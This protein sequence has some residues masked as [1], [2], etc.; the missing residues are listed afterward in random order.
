VR[1]TTSIFTQAREDHQEVGY[2]LSK[3]MSP[4]H[5]GETGNVKLF[6]CLTKFHDIKTSCA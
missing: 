4:L 3:L 2:N 1:S 5:K 6:L